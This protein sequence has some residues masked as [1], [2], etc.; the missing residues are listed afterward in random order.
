MARPECP[1][2]ELAAKTR[3]LTFALNVGLPGRVWASG[4][5]IVNPK[6]RR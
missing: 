2:E 5:P 4:K 6:Y 1:A 3:E